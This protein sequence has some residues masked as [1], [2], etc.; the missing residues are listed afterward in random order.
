MNKSKIIP[1]Y[2]MKEIIKLYPIFND[3]FSNDLN[4]I[5]AKNFYYEL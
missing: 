5:I 1:D 2:R 4:L 3:K